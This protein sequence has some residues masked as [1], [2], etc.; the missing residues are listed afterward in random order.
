MLEGVQLFCFAASYAVALVVESG[1]LFF[2]APVRPIVGLV[3]G[4]I[5]LFAHTVYLVNE[6]RHASPAAGELP[7][8]SWKYW[9]LMAAWVLVAAYLAMSAKRSARTLG[10]FILP[11]VFL[12]IG[13]AW[14]FPA[15]AEPFPRDQAYRYWSIVHGVALLLGTVVVMLGFVAGL[16]YLVQSYRLKH[17]LAPGRGLQLPS[18]E[19][20]Q[21]MNED[22]FVLSTCLL[23]AGL[24]SGVV[25]NLIRQTSANTGLPWTDPVVWT[26]GLLFAWLAASSIFNFVYKP[27]RQGQKV[28]Y[29][30]VASFV[31]LG[32]ALGVVLFSPTSHASQRAA[33]KEESGNRK[34]ES[35]KPIAESRKP[36]AESR[37]PKTESRSRAGFE[38]WRQPVSVQLSAFGFPLSAFSAGGAA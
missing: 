20:L 2:R 29:L 17:K 7:L 15:L 8:S 28:A 14:W 26:S 1:R 36:I 27:A 21:R 32:L 18:L 19:W 11:L 34:A 24:I 33:A 37:K 9:C 5:G 16:M 12:L 30:T 13:V 31:F 3:I 4:G 25:L 6:A 22:S 35:G 23:A 38:D 10:V